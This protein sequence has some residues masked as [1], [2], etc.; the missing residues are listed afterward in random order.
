[1]RARILEFF[2]GAGTAAH[3]YDIDTGKLR[4]QKLTYF[5]ATHSRHLRV[6]DNNVV[7]VVVQ[8]VNRLDAVVCLIHAMA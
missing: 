1:M 7:P 4:L 5:D 2:Q 3:A 6:C 8:P